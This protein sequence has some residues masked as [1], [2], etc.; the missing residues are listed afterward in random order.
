[1]MKLIENFPNFGTIFCSVYPMAFKMPSDGLAPSVLNII[2]GLP[3][4][5]KVDM[6]GTRFDEARSVNTSL[7]FLGVKT[8]NM[9][10]KTSTNRVYE[11]GWSSIER[12]L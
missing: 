2:Q 6:P 10:S 1:M 9:H 4:N 11:G 7:S 8:R 12:W 3:G 5:V